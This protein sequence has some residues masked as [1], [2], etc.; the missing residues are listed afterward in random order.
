MLPRWLNPK[1]NPAGLSAVAAAVYAAVVMIVNAVHHH[2]VIDVPVIVAALAA[3]A[4]LLTRQAVTPVADPRGTAG[5]QLVPLSEPRVSA[6]IDAAAQA[7]AR[8][9]VGWIETHQAS[10]PGW[11]GG[12]AGGTFGSASGGGSPGGATGGPGPGMLP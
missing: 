12:G 9:A 4:S 10:V 11:P 7:A 5:T 2:G 6:M 8:A 1:L 3:V